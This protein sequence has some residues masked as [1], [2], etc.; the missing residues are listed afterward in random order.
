MTTAWALIVAAG[1]GH[2]VGGPV[3]KQYRSLSGR[4]VLDRTVRRFVDH[5]AID[6][7]RVAIHP[8]DRTLYDEAI[9]PETAA[10]KPIRPI[11]GGANRQES[12]HLGLES[13]ADTSPDLVLIHDGARPLV[14]SAAI[15][16]VVAA[17]AEHDGAVAAI[18]INDAVKLAASAGG[19]IA[20]TVPREGLWRAQTPQG[21]RYGA[22]LEAHRSA[23]GHGLPDDAA[24]AERA[25]LSVALTM[26]D[27]DNLK[28]T[29]EGDFAR[30]ERILAVQEAN[31]ARGAAP[32][33]WETRVGTGYDVHRFG[34]GDHVMLCGL[35]VPHE[36][37]IVGHS[38]GDIALH[39]VVDAILGAI[40][41]GDIGLHFPPSDET[42]RDADSA[43]FASH[44]LGL[45]KARGGVLDHVDVTVICERPRIG[46]HRAAMTARLS[47]ILG[48]EPGRVNLKGTTT[49][50]MG[51]TGRGEGIAAQAV[52]TVRLPA[53]SA[54]NGG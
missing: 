40:G 46:P 3:P 53:I 9:R 50:R 44:A 37:G 25:G 4:A 27:E 39:A 26:G 47:A 14:P 49:E 42:W 12:V 34:P 23:A 52:A 8:N 41:A 19:A 15:D 21:F 30:A 48:L 13:L 38:D 28:L 45:L 35:R 54:G 32:P 20:G 7:V 16:R 24:V 17:L 2:R 31:M 43:R 1:R 36:Q 29:T 11:D 33:A 51:F 6:G 10:G 22:I 18:P 5:P